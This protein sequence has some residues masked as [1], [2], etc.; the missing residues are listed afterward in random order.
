MSTHNVPA[1]TASQ[2]LRRMRKLARL[3]AHAHKKRRPARKAHLL[4][5]LDTYTM[6]VPGVTVADALHV[7]G[8]VA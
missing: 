1:F 4:T 8:G 2:A 5:Q 3:I 6:M 7:L